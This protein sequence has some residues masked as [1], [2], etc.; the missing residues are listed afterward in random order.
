MMQNKMKKKGFVGET[1]VDAL[2]WIIFSIAIGY[3]IYLIAKNLFFSY[4]QGL[5]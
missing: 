1:L 3:G 2:L 4:I 5:N